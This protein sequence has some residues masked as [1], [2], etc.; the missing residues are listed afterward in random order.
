MEGAAPSRRGNVK[1]SLGGAE[2][3]EGEES[4]E[5]EVA[6]AP[7]ASEAENLAHSNQPLVSQ[8]EP[9]FLKMMEQMTQIMVQLTQEVSS[10]NNYKATQFKT[11]SMKAPDYFDSTKDHKLRGFIQAFQLV[12]HNDPENFFSERK[13]ALYSISFLTS[14]AAKWI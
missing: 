7:E 5:T 2:H 13:K 14:R 6:G 12:F 8:A 10:R 11:P 1:S 3:E 4:E 9:K